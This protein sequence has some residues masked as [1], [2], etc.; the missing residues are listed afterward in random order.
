MIKLLKIFVALC[1]ATFS[2]HLLAENDT[3]AADSANAVVESTE[4]FVENPAQREPVGLIFDRTFSQVVGAEAIITAFRGYQ[5]LDDWIAPSTAGNTSGSMIAGRFGKAIFEGLLST[6]AM[7]TQHEVFGHGARAR[8]FDIHVYRYSIGP[9]GGSTS[10]NATK[11]NQLS[12]NEQIAFTAGGMEGSN[13]L[14]RQI[15]GRWLRSQ[16]IDSRE[17]SLYFAVSYLDQT[18]YIMSTKLSNR[19][20]TFPIGHDVFQYVNEVNRWNRGQ[21]LTTHKLR[22]QALVDFLDPYLYYSIYSIG[23]YVIDGCQLW[24][25]P[26]IPIGEYRFLPMARLVLAPYGPEYQLTTLIKGPE[27]NIIANFR[28]GNTGRQHSSALGIEVSDILSSDLLFVDGKVELWNQPKL[29]TAFASGRE[30]LGAAASLVA[31]YR[32][33]KQLDVLGQAGYKTT[34]FIPG[35]ELKHGPILRVGFMLNI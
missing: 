24:E 19:D 9:F 11:F 33:I 21:T 28:Y 31:R 16:S 23:L 22:K 26:M 6:T 4:S 10:F 32:V 17:A 25:Y 12:L 2:T 5:L 29:Y 3:F 8:E 1:L 14:G 15:R 35:E 27:R 13:I 34:G 18:Q 30:K 7:V 20:R